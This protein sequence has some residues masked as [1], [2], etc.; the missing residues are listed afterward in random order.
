MQS[1]ID[2]GIAKSRGGDLN[3]ALTMSGKKQPDVVKLRMQS[4]PQYSP[5]PAA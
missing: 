2:C 4:G 1:G 5:E 3:A